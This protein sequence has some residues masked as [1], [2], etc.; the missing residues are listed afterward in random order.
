MS[1]TSSTWDPA[2]YL[3]FSNERL[4]P[5]LDLLSQI[6]LETAKNVVDLGCGT[7]SMTTIL[8]QRFASAAVL[9][10]DG[11]ETMLAKARA[12]APECRFEQGDF[13]TWTPAAPPDLIF[14]NAALHWITNHETVFPRLLSL[15]A[16]GGIL[17]VQMPAMHDAPLRALQNE[18]AQTDPWPSLLGETGYARGLLPVE[19]YYDVIRPRVTS[20]DLWETTYLHVLTGPDAVTEWA[21]GSSLR[22]FLDKLPADRAAEFRAAYSA[23][24]RP[25]YPR[26]PDG[27]TLLPFKR[28]FLVARI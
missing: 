3:K 25:H 23:A 17:A 16:P 4:R 5:A 15:L 22:P 12:A 2:Q 24:L 26:R 28:L 14:S 9:G 11:A 27:T 6:P 1:I 20:L 8:K 21:A 10:V 7:G 19:T 18:I 13:A